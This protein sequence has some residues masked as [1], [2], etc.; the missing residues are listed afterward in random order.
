MRRTLGCSI[1][2][3][4]RPPERPKGI[5]WAV[6]VIG[7]LAPHAGLSQEAPPS[8]LGPNA[9][10]AIVEA[11]S[12]FAGLPDSSR[13]A[14]LLEKQTGAAFP[15]TDYDQVLI[16][17]LWR[18]AGKTKLAA[19]TLNAVSGQS[20]AI[21]PAIYEAA[22]MWL[23]AGRQRS[24][25]RA[26]WSV[27]GST[28]ERARAEIARDL[29]AEMTPDERSSWDQLGPGDS[30]CRW[31][32]TFWNERAMRAG[33]RQAER[34]AIHFERLRQ[35]R[36]E[37]H[38]DRP[39]ELDGMADEDGR[40]KGLAVDDRGLLLIRL[41]APDHQE[42]CPEEIIVD[43]KPD[44]A[45]EELN[46]TGVCWVYDR[47]QGY[48]IFYLSTRDRF[49]PA[50]RMGYDRPSGDYRIQES[51]SQQAEPGTE[52]FQK[53]VMNADLPQETKRRLV[54]RGPVY[55]NAKLD[56]AGF[57]TSIA[58]TL[59]G[60]LDPAEYAALRHEVRDA[61]RGYAASV[62]EQVP[63]V[64]NIRS[65]VQLRYEA[66]RFLNPSDNTWQVWLLGSVRAG[67][68]TV[69]PANDGEALGATGHYVALHDGTLVNGELS[70]LSVPTS[71]PENAG[72]PLRGVFSSTPG[73]VPLT[74][75]VEDQ[76][77]PGSGAW[78]QDTVQVPA[79]GG[80]PQL[81]DIAIAQSEGGSWTRD[82]KTY[83]QV[84]P[85]HVSNPDGSI[86]TYFEVYGVDPGTRYDV[87]FRMVPTD[88]AE[89]IWRI[90]PDDLA[91]RLQFTS[92]MSGAIG[93]HHLRLDLGDTDPG[94]YVLAV[95][96]QDEETKAYSLPSVTDVFVPER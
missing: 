47:P 56:S 38:L 87:E 33:M 71:V 7:I 53:Y 49:G 60:N 85:A 65:T 42:S 26:Y 3:N 16:A 22:R 78:V 74:F 11:L 43:G 86:Q 95:R 57:R 35:A 73:S 28:D 31:L 82:G 23:E 1:C 27:C 5:P 21:G 20:P 84:T 48:L 17:R 37:Y 40:P 66:L 45:S 30:T 4:A 72:L 94:S 52:Y 92:R 79:I 83:L 2:Q 62:L 6:L 32:R 14:K 81:S 59:Y 63:D 15:A 25:A 80:L 58:D 24:G 9:P 10:P 68:L 55:R 90:E 12:P 13:I 76:N 75:V 50:D 18:L 89:R 39:R 88:A 36:R 93:R 51:L 70:S 8:A 34:L 54:E 61:T 64:P 96:I 44:R 19:A 77:A 67:D 41:G 46:L 29:R 69:G 91:F